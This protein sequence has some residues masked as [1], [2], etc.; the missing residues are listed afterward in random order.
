MIDKD[1]IIDGKIYLITNKINGKMYCG[2]TIKPL[3]RRFKAHTKKTSKCYALTKAIQYFGDENFYFDQID[4]ATTY[5]E[6]NMK[7]VY[8][9]ETLKTM[10]PNGYNTRFGGRN[11]KITNET[12]EKIKKTLTGTK[13]TES[14]RRNNSES[15]WNQLPKKGRKY[16]GT[17]YFKNIKKFQSAIT[18]NYKRIFLGYFDTEE[19][20]AKVYNN[21]VDK[22]RDGKGY[23]NDV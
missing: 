15:K 6:L 4:S 10:S 18:V 3:I 14:H 17:S 1:E 8:W 22:Y 19:E 23:K 20:A 13:Q 2:Q 11:G 16:K 12:K 7:E 9:I 5:K 21:A